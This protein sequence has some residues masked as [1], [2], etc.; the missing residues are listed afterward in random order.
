MVFA[1]SG[2]CYRMK[3]VLCQ[4][5]WKCHFKLSSDYVD[6]IHLDHEFSCL[7]SVAVLKISPY[8]YENIL[9]FK[10]TWRLS[11]RKGIVYEY[12]CYIFIMTFIQ[13]RVW[14]EFYIMGNT[15]LFTIHNIYLKIEIKVIPEK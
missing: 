2:K 1:T 11:L 5:Y 9:F 3:Q 7:K 15:I 8:D 14:M 13:F 10:K 6:E 12:C 4:N